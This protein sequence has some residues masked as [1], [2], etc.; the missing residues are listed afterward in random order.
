MTHMCM[1]QDRISP[2]NT[3]HVTFCIW[4]TQLDAYI[5]SLP[6]LKL[7]DLKSNFRQ[8]RESFT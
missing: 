2:Y 5:G 3:I 8:G 7:S 1:L 4:K 6:W